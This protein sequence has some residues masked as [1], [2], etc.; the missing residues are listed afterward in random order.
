MNDNRYRRSTFTEQKA[1]SGN[2]GTSTPQPPALLPT[3]PTA[4]GEGNWTAR[5]ALT[6][7]VPD[8]TPPAANARGW[9]R[10]RFEE[11]LVYT[12]QISTAITA[13]NRVL[14]EQ[15]DSLQALE[16]KHIER[17]PRI[18]LKQIEL[19]QKIALARESLKGTEREIEHRRFARHQE[20]L[21]DQ[22]NS[23][24]DELTYKLNRAETRAALAEAEARADAA[25]Q[26]AA[27]R[28]QTAA[29]EAEADLEKA[30]RKVNL[31]KERRIDI[32]MDE[33]DNVDDREPA[34]FREELA[35]GR[36]REKIRKAA[37][38]REE[39]ILAEVGG[40]ETK[41]SQAQ[42]DRREEIRGA[43]HR[44]LKNIDLGAATGTI[45]PDDDEEQ[46]Q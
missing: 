8:L 18:H 44:S 39:D 10:R 11:Q 32:E 16:E 6:L 19:T 20:V 14:T 45:F 26:V 13:V 27:H 9:K 12:Q 25:E 7:S 28:A 37:R 34:A 30:R 2:N 36:E 35:R 29:Y 40:D 5:R 46:P 17:A 22:R 42:R 21:N 33:V 1:T 23:E 4:N 31:A 15:E 38:R 43:A 41:L 24:L 3:A